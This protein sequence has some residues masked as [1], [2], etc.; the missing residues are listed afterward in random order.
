METVNTVSS[1]TR[2]NKFE[3]I[4]E[5]SFKAVNS[6]QGNKEMTFHVH[7]LVDSFCIIFQN[8]F[9]DKASGSALLLICS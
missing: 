2:S 4:N 1:F 5:K 7:L 9:Y 3:K 8:T 6:P